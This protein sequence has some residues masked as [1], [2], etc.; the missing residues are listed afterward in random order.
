MDTSNSTSNNPVEQK[1]TDIIA[2]CDRIDF[3][4]REL[5]NSV[6]ATL[7]EVA[8][9]NVAYN[10]SF[11]PPIAESEPEPAKQPEEEIIPPQPKEEVIQPQSKEEVTPPPIIQPPKYTKP[12]PSPPPPQKATEDEERTF[13][14]KW[15]A[16]I[17]I[18]IAVIGLSLL[19]KYLIENDLLGPVAIVSLGY[20]T[21]LTLV[22]FS[23]KVAETR[24]V[25]KDTL[26][27]GGTTLGW[28]ITWLA[29]GHYDMFPSAVTVAITLA[30][31]TGLM[32]FAYTH[33]N[34]IMFHF[35]L[36]GF[37][38]SPLVSGY[39]IK[40]H[41]IFWMSFTLAYNLA[42][43]YLYKTKQWSSAYV[44]SFFITIILEVFVCDYGKSVS[45]TVH[46][47][48]YTAIAAALY[49]GAIMLYNHLKE[50]FES[51][52]LAFIVLDIVF[53]LIVTY[54]EFH[55]NHNTTSIAYLLFAAALGFTAYMFHR[56]KS[57]EKP[58]YKTPFTLACII[59]N[60]AFL[61]H[62]FPSPLNHWIPFLLSIDI[63]LMAILYRRSGDEVYKSIG[64]ICMWLNFIIL[65]I[66]TPFF[67]ESIKDNFTMI[68]NIDLAGQLMF[69]TI[70]IY[71][72]RTEFIKQTFGFAFMIMLCLMLSVAL[73]NYRYWYFIRHNYSD[74]VLQCVTH[75]CITIMSLLG[76]SIIMA[77]LPKRFEWLKNFRTLGMYGLLVSV[78]Y[79]C[80]SGIYVL[81]SMRDHIASL[82]ASYHGWRYA[83]LG[84]TFLATFF[85][86]RNRNENLFNNFDKLSDIVAAAAI[87][88]LVAAE[89]NNMFHLYDLE[90]RK[91]RM[92]VTLW[93]T[94]SSVALFALGLKFKL[95]HL[96]IFGFVMI[97]ITIL[98]LFFID[99]W[100]TELIVKA[101]VFVAIGLLFL[102]I[103]YIYS[104]Y[105]KDKNDSTHNITNT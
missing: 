87:I 12:T 33:D 2:W 86:I 22:G 100:K 91:Y 20:I 83:S 97:G 55:R 68:F 60:I 36:V 16:V 51:V 50:K 96:R 8:Y 37:I 9:N 63:I 62:E 10:N 13:G 98:K 89:I 29:Y 82:P 45:E 61:L 43:L 99:I 93:F 31:S 44:I 103:S 94:I 53:L 80:I 85:I 49:A 27:I 69:V 64:T 71:L 39:S 3:Q 74:E 88:W 21:S 95:K 78:F 11:L 72:Y 84:M 81:D 59:F 24:K 76:C 30:I 42:L 104:K 79:F 35:A 17:G 14:V 77:N 25:L 4:I 46:V 66:F 19:I 32:A 1:L 90:V 57:E 102:L 26:M 47:A 105:F 23:L 58:L 15:M 65:Y 48:Y 41:D 6:N 34:K 92:F 67:G 101:I 28:M 18:L 40:Q 38:F 5:R 54:C 70:L 7:A 52:S 75:L 56:F 73:S